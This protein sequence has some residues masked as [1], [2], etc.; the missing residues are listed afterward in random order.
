M[1]SAPAGECSAGSKPKA[2]TGVLDLRDWD[3]AAAGPVNLTGEYEF[4]WRQFISPD[5][6]RAAATPQKTGL[7]PVPRSWNGYRFDALE[8]PGVGFATYRL[9]ILLPQKVPPLALKFLDMG[10]AFTVFANGEKILEVGQTGS[11]P[12]TSKPR[13]LPQVADLPPAFQQLELIYWVS[14]FHHRRG[15]TWEVVRLGARNKIHRVRERRLAF[16]LILFGGIFVMGLYHLAFFGLRRR[17]A[18]PIFFGFF[19][20]LIGVRLLCTV[21]RYLLQFFPRIPWEVFVK[22]EYLSVYFAVPIFILF[23]KSLFEDEVDRRIVWLMGAVYLMLSAIVFTTPVAIFSYTSIFF[24]S[25]IVLSFVYG[26]YVLFLALQRKRDGALI[27]LSGFVVLFATVVNDILDVNEVIQTGHYVQLGLLV[28]I[29]SQAYMLSFRYSRAF[30]TID[31]QRRDLEKANEDYRRELHERQ[32]AEQEKSELQERLERSQ[33]MEALGLLA[34]GVAHDLNNILSGIVTYPDLLLMDLP[35]RSKLKEPLETIRNSGLRAA[36]VV[37]DLL[38]LARRGVLQ[39]EPLDLNKLLE[40]YLNSPEHVKIMSAHSD[41]KIA[42]DFDSQ[43]LRI[44]GSSHHLKKAFMNLITNAAEAQPEG[45]SIRVATSNCYVDRPMNGYEQIRE[46]NYVVVRIEDEGVGI[47]PDDLSKIF[48]PFY[49]KKVMGRSGSG[50]GMAVVWGVVH[51]HRGFIDVQTRAGEGTT[52]EIYFAVTHDECVKKASKVPVHQ[53]TGK[54]ERI[55]VVDDVT[56]QR[57]IATMILTRLGYQVS[58]A[59][60][61]EEAVEF[62][63]QNEVDLLVLDMIMDPGIDGLET[64][65][66]IVSIRPGVR[67]IIASGYSETDRVRLAQQLGAGSYIRKPYTL[68]KMGLAVR[69]ELDGSVH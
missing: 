24:E 4:Y 62:V 21:E 38:T 46:G 47:A 37:Q 60:S 11:M 20:L 16:D 23:L 43:L 35:K 19:C 7:M 6:F 28:F 25:F 55:L 32:R 3:F 13:Y 17:D 61:G 39:F 18:S 12:A 29:F 31:S 14:N 1:L 34:G 57:E 52:F 49:T 67:A 5:S 53:Y 42:I 65:K 33:K 48:E 45:G 2:I 44:T 59:A 9:S 58:S 66:R 10:T 68:E 56:E 64:Y 51:D 27:F 15:G 63:K 26:C 41:V 36:A 40:E 30:I 54:N 50:L 22:I 8:L 69:A